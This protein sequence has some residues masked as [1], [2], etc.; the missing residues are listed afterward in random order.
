M[1]ARHSVAIV[2]TAAAG[3]LVVASFAGAASTGGEQQ[4]D[5]LRVVGFGQD[6]DYVDPALGY[7]DFSW[8][9]QNAVCARL[10]G[11][12]DRPA[13]EGAN[14]VPEV[15]KT[16]P[17]YSKNGRTATIELRRTY[18]FHTGARVT[19]ASFVAAINRLADPR[20]KSPAT[21]YLVDVVG[22][23]AV[24]EGRARSI[25]GIRAVGAFT[26]R[27]RTTR[28][29]GDLAAR[30]SMPFFCPLPRNTPVDPA[31]I[32]DPA[33]SGP[34]YVASRV[35][36]RQLV[37]ERNRF[38]HGPRK[39]RVGRIV[40]SVGTGREACRVAV[41]QNEADY[42]VG[43]VPAAVARSYADRYELNRPGGQLFFNV[44]NQTFHVAFNHS[45]R[46][47]KSPGQ[48]PLK[49]AI[50]WAID[51][52]AL[53]RA[54]GAL[55]G[56]R[57]DQILPPALTR[58]ASLYP[59]EGVTPRSL[60]RA[61]ALM[62]QA[63][64]KP[65]TLVLYAPNFGTF[66]A[67]AQIFQFN[68]KRLGI[69][70]EIKFFSPDA[71][72]DRIGRR[73]E[74]FDVTITGWAADYADGAGFFGPGLD[75]RTLK[76]TGNTN[77]S[78]FDRPKVNR[79]IARINVLQGDARRRAWA[80]LDAELMRDDPPWAPFYN[81]ARVELVSEDLGCYVFSPVFGRLNFVAACKK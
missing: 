48:V 66:P 74:P 23:K 3:L 55:V 8:S 73:G 5:T 47:F 41:E 79:A 78:Y 11:Y 76:P 15:A 32:D 67:R 20:M 22:A 60:A 59:L 37:L 10:Y 14:V 42:C 57:T 69:D 51:R 43:G 12:P 9:F 19:A 39:V 2:A 65:A 64:L 28:R 7:V 70:V 77:Y 24:L 25:S 81:P 33:G 54:G 29:A 38:Y 52:P 49:Q 30:L 36:G 34:F 68:M 50:N 6:I 44:L 26:L 63:K 45:R 75:G 4:S 1:R 56:R 40:F 58:P 71:W 61:R 21:G 27:I 62:S 72:L 46:A 53:V 80:A 18:R 13:P 31:G 35:K 17:R 16:L